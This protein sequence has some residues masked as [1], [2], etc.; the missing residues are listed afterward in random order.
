MLKPLLNNL[1][2]QLVKNAPSVLSFPSTLVPF[3]IQ[4][5]LLSELLICLFKEA[6]E[7]DELDFLE[8][9]WLK[10]EVS[11][12]GF[13]WYISFENN[14]LIIQENCPKVD[15]TFSGNVNDLILIAG[16]KEDPDT[17]FFQ[18]RLSIQG[19]TELGLEV[20]NL[21]DNIDFDNLPN[22]AKQAIEHFSSFIQQG[23]D[24]PLKTASI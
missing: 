23:I 11:D 1:Q 18:R 22:L 21:L 19:D 20:K 9:K 8:D 12:L 15:V 13:C 4:K 6:I 2:H 16:R 5:K 7:D 24:A 14:Q 10:V 17:L 3:F